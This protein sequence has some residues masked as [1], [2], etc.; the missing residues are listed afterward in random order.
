MAICIRF[1]EQVIF[2]GN[3]MQMEAKVLNIMTYKV[4]INLNI[5]SVLVKNIV[6]SMWVMLQLSQW[7]AKL[8]V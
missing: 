7:I 1:G 2:R 3:K 5:F 4:A 6:M 8:V